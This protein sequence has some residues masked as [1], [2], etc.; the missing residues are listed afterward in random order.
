MV[1]GQI[2]RS[3]ACPFSTLLQ[4]VVKETVYVVSGSSRFDGDEDGV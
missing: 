1:V 2:W 3:A 4:N